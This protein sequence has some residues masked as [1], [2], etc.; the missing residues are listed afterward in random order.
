M[1]AFSL[2]EG[3][4]GSANKAVRHNSLPEEKQSSAFFMSS[5]VGLHS[6]P[7]S[8]PVKLS[9]ASRFRD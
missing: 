1:N 8:W 9:A 7:T 2:K 5:Q 4:K 6:V 3:W